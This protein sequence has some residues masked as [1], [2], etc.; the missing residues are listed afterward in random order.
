MLYSN[1]EK[2]LNTLLNAASDRQKMLAHNLTNI[3]TPG[4]NQRQDLDFSTVVRNTQHGSGSKADMSKAIENASFTDDQKPTFETEMSA[5]FEN[6]LKYILLTRIN[7]HI[8][9]HMQEATQSG[10]GS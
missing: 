7:G 8:Y 9:Q 1:E 5:M 2:I 6:Q 3:H 10:R 4:Y